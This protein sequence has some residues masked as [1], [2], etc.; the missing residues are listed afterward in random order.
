[1]QAGVT[2]I[3]DTELVI[4]IVLGSASFHLGKKVTLSQDYNPRSDMTMQQDKL[5]ST[6]KLQAF[7]QTSPKRQ[8]FKHVKGVMQAQEAKSA[9]CLHDI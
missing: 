3:K 4:P 6:P 9:T 8:A 7:W 2:R 1:M 5:Q